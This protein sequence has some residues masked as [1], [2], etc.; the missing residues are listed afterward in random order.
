MVRSGRS[1]GSM[2]MVPFS[3]AWAIGSNAGTAGPKSVTGSIQSSRPWISTGAELVV[4]DLDA[5]SDP[6]A[7]SLPQGFRPFVG[8]IGTPAGDHLARA[9]RLGGKKPAGCADRSQTLRAGLPIRCV[10]PAGVFQGACS[11]F[12][13][14][15]AGGGFS[16]EAEASASFR[17]W[18]QA[19]A[20]SCYWPG[21][22]QQWLWLATPSDS[23]SLVDAR[24]S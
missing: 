9:S 21:L 18:R 3:F 11:A 5:E 16:D 1:L 22:P 7:D 17:K 23:G 8:R 13:E 2:R 4:H 6:R 20:F 24:R 12:E 19:V 15:I 14:T 10:V